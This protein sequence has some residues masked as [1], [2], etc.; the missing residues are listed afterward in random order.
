MTPALLSATRAQLLD[1]VISSLGNIS[2]VVPAL[3][4]SVG[5]AVLTEEREHQLGSV[6]ELP[7]GSGG[8]WVV[9]RRVPPDAVVE[10]SL[11]QTAGGVGIASRGL[12]PDAVVLATLYGPEHVER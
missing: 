9:V 11:L 6:L 1:L 8:G 4:D 12:D 10:G 3:R 5:V 7:S 2:T